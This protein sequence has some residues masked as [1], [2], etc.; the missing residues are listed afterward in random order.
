MVPRQHQ[1]AL[2]Q[3]SFTGPRPGFKKVTDNIGRCNYGTDNN[4]G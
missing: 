2:G 1:E 4:F 3:L